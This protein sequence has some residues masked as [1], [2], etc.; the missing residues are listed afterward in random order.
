M[1]EEKALSEALKDAIRYLLGRLGAPLEGDLLQLLVRYYNISAR[2]PPSRPWQVELSDELQ[3]QL[4][5]LPEGIRKGVELFIAAAEQGLNLLPWLHDGLFA[6]QQDDLWND[7][8]IQHFHLGT[9]LE[10]SKCCRVRV[11]RTGNLLY[12]SY[13]NEKGVLCLIAVFDHESFSKK[14]LVEIVH[15]HWPWLI[16]HARVENV[17]DICFTP[18]DPDIRRLRK[19]QINAVIEVDGVFYLPMGG[20][21]TLSGHSTKAVLW[22]QSVIKSLPGLLSKMSAPRFVLDGSWICLVDERGQLQF[23]LK[24]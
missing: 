5:L 23:V 12:G 16:E 3:K 2:I 18:D 11:N 9:Q 4:V 7:W 17:R 20:G 22:A 15:Q 21:M 13:C 1:D 8:G 14:Q 19:N 24:P 6:N 10:L